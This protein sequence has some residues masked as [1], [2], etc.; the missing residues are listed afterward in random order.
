LLNDL[1]K[2]KKAFLMEQEQPGKKGKAN[3]SSSGKRKM[4]SIHEPIPKKP[5]KD[6]KHCVLCTRHGSMHVIHNALDCCKYEKDGKIKKGFGK[7]QHGSTASNK[8]TAS[9][10]A[11]LLAKIAKLEKAN[12]KLKKSLQKRKHDYG[13]DSDDSDSS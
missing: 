11:Q 10:F 8:K 6:V 5:R 7:G 12:E 9:A 13:S 2:I 1:E 3:P 4:G